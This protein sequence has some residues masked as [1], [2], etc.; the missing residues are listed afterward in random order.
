MLLKTLFKLRSEQTP[1]IGSLNT[2]QT[3]ITSGSAYITLLP[4]TLDQTFPP[5]ILQLNLSHLTSIL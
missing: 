2:E 5:L 4:D 3:G 1:V